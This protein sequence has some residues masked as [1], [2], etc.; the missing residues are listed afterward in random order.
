MREQEGRTILPRTS[1]LVAPLGFSLALFSSSCSVDI[2]PVHNSRV[3]AAKFA[4]QPL[5][6]GPQA[7]GAFRHAWKFE[8][9]KGYLF[10]PTE[11]EISE[12]FARLKGSAAAVGKKDAV[13]VTRHGIHYAALDSLEETSG[14][15]NQGQ[16][17][18]QFSPDSSTW[19]FHDGKAWV[20]AGPTSH[21]TNSA[22]EARSRLNVFHNEVGTGQLFLKIFLVSP[23]G[24]ELVE[25]KE[26]TLHGVAT[27]T[28]G[29]D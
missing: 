20:K 18:Y 19:Y 26:V 9:P 21:F 2:V 28:D 22:A 29:W 13:L 16:I 12:G 6:R 14:P 23:S 15:R 4:E 11:V 5:L 17:R 24:K 25:L 1:L 10:D 8:G 27:P 3:N 7:P